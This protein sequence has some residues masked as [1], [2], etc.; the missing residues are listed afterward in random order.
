MGLCRQ[1]GV[2]IRT[3]EIGSQSELKLLQAGA[4]ARAAPFS[5]PPKCLHKT[6]MCQCWL[7]TF[8]ELRLKLQYAGTN[9][10]AA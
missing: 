4:M 1:G 10:S 6:C 7:A 3:A 2:S 5:L 9:V 8:S